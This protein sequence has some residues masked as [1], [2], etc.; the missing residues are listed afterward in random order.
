M[1]NMKL[2]EVSVSDLV[3]LLVE[4]FKQA[5]DPAP[6]P[7][8][9]ALEEFLRDDIVYLPGAGFGVVLAVFQQEVFTEPSLVV[10]AGGSVFDGR[11]SG[12]SAG[13]CA[14]TIASSSAVRARPSWSSKT[15]CAG[16]EAQPAGATVPVECPSELLDLLMAAT[17]R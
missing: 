11:L 5:P 16:W 4:A 12:P 10:L 7:V 2:D 15:G 13:L 1:E 3:D 14:R 6:D 8:A 9:P 17:D